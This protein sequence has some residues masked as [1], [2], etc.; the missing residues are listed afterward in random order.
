MQ[1]TPSLKTIHQGGV[2]P[3]WSLIG[4]HLFYFI[5]CWKLLRNWKASGRLGTTH[6][7]PHMM[8]PDVNNIGFLI[9]YINIWPS[10]TSIPTSIFGC[11]PVQYELQLQY[12]AEFHFNININTNIAFLFFNINISIIQGHGQSTWGTSKTQGRRKK[13]FFNH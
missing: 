8:A 3:I 7:T 10:A 12:W 9:Q 1:S 2:V 6:T 11:I 13:P 5:I 4:F